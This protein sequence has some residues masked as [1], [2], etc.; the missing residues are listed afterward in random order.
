MIYFEGATL[1]TFFSFLVIYNYIIPISLYVT[2]EMQRFI[3][4]LYIFWDEKF[5]YRADGEEQRYF[6]FNIFYE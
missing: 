5:F 3:S 6:I 1:V 2:V 4:A